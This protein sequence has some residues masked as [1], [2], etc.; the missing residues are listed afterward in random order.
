M[1]CNHVCLTQ[2]EFRDLSRGSGL[3]PSRQRIL[4]PT[5]SLRRINSEHS[6]FELYLSE[7][8]ARLPLKAFRGVR[9]ISQFD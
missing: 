8:N 7:S 6:E 4:A 2:R 9:A 5:A 1:Q 3:L